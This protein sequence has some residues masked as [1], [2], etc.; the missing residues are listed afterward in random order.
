MQ[1]S[2]SRANVINALEIIST[3]YTTVIRTQLMNDSIYVIHELLIC[4]ECAQIHFGY[5][6]W[7]RN[8]VC[9]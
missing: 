2:I 6:E 5:G 7:E 1:V 4:L 8:D 3:L 9:K